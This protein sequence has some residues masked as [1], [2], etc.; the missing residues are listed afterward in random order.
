MRKKGALP[1]GDQDAQEMTDSRPGT[2][3]GPGHPAH[4]GGGGGTAPTPC[5]PLLTPPVSQMRRCSV[6][7]T[8]QT[9]AFLQC[10]TAD[11]GVFWVCSL[12]P[13]NNLFQTAS[14]HRLTGRSDA[15]LT[16]GHM[17]HPRS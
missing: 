6:N 5:P 15:G 7:K 2:R 8:R 1:A 11:S 4:Q 16:A 3:R 17:E 13:L 9:G 14:G 12:S 10:I